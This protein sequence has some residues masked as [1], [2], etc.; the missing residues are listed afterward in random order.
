MHI[1]CA[2][3]ERS[4]KNLIVAQSGGPTSA[5]NA[6]L[7]GVIV[8]AQKSKEIDKI[9][10]AC[11]G[12]QGVLEEKFIDLNRKAD[13]QDK[14]EMLKRTP[15]AALGSCRFKLED[16]EKDDTQFRQIVD[17]F[18]KY[19]IGYFIYIGGNDSMDTVYKLSAYCEKNGIDDI[20]VIGGPKT[21]DNDLCG[22]DHCPGFGSAAKYIATVFAELEQ[23][24]NVYETK[25][26][27]IVEMMGRNAGWLTAAAA[28]AEKKNGKTP[29]LIYLEERTF[30]M[31]K[32]ISDV[33]EELDAHDTVLVAVS[34]GV[35]DEEGRYICDTLPGESDTDVFGHSM[36]S[37]TGRVLEE[38]VKNKI[39]CK[40]RS[41]ELNLL[42]R[43]ASHIM[44]E[45]D[46]NE[47]FNLG[48][49]AVRIAVSGESGKMSSLK[50]IPSDKYEVEYCAVDIANVANL[51]KKVPVSWINETGNGVTEEMID[52]LLPLIQ[53]ELSCFYDNGVPD[54]LVLK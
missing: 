21:I 37:G 30:S 50:R 13:T 2:G 48:Q 31:E 39:G 33:K 40:V 29:Y 10:G 17:I 12:I 26:V 8:E 35:H 25:S 42:Q 3:M 28:L 20:K 11:Y 32:F 23:E 24:I 18:H 38:E 52:Y 49:N 6:T 4:M 46:I 14:I 34:E 19:N 51:E 7:A 43:C 27:I 45:T 53:G 16:P 44:S 1:G 9:Y 54:Y 15:A 47:S 41:I 5:I 36:L 22:I